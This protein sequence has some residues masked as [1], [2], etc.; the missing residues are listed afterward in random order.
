M[1]NCNDYI[2]A[3]DLKTGKQA[4]LHIEHVAK[5]RDANGRAALEVTDTIRGESV[6]NPTL[7]GFFSS[8]GFKPAD[9]SFEDG[10]TIN[11]RWEVLLYESEGSYYQWMG[12]LPKVVPPGS[13]PATT[14]G[15]D[16]THWINQTDLTL[17]SDLSKENGALLI[18]GGAITSFLKKFNFSTGGTLTNNRE[19]VKYNDG[20]WYVWG[21]SFPKTIDTSTPD[22]DTNW[23]CVG[24]LNG[25]AVNDA[26]NFG[27]TGG[28]SDALPALNAMIRS[29]FFNMFFPMG[30]EI[31]IASDWSL[32]SNLHIDFH[33]STINWKGAVFT[34]D[35]VANG[36]EMAILNTPNFSGG[37]TGALVNLHLSNLNI[38]A[39]DYAI[40]ISVR[41]ITN[42][43]IENVYVEK[44]QRQGINVSNCQNGCINQITLK[45][46]SPLSDKGFT[47]TQLE[48]WG[49]GLIV[50]YGSTNVSINNIRVESGNN[51]RGGRCGIVVDG[52]SPTGKPD[53]RIISINN[54]YVYGYDRP[55][56]TELCGVVTVMDSVFEYNSGSDTHHFLQCG[57]VV[58]N[59]LETTTFINCTFRT[60]MRFMKNSGAKAKFIK[61]N[62]YKTSS[63]EPM[64]ITGT[65]STGIV[66]FDDCLLSHAGGEWGAWNC[67]LSFNGCTI[68]SDAPGSVID[69]GSAEG[70][71]KELRISNS[72]LKNIGITALFAPAFTE[73]HLTNSS[74][75]GDVNC[76]DH[77]RLFVSD[78][79][80]SGDV[81]CKSVM[82]YS[83]AKPKSL[84]FTQNGDQQYNGHWLGTGKPVAGR[85]D[86][87]GDWKRGDTVL[88][89]DATESNAYLWQ[90][91]TAGSPGRWSVAGSLGAGV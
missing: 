21:G 68:S 7:D 77:A 65:E 60:D 6:T 15:I 90:C 5:S 3:D 48:S 27:F 12:V 59:V 45:D 87:S 39:N 63:T 28:M 54:A 47:S 20:F 56:H 46:C 8:V 75:P 14:G 23:K 74:I 36:S 30:S 18:D 11:H 66:N 73:I 34:L 24:L 88:N 29:P 53:T 44:A 33:A 4:I 72:S 9:G 41:N 79:N 37:T 10:G 78:C 1:A 17:R 64:F 84:G 26:Q 40:G 80:I 91:V 61:C 76:G 43:S 49:D 31:N 67:S 16:A 83:G 35:D 38:K 89:L 58:W 32:R 42:F 19:A 55:I 81:S 57:V 82:R 2:S 51:S 85:P 86:G 69:F 50:W 25:Y 71:P 62:V 22:T 13:T 52:Y 70:A